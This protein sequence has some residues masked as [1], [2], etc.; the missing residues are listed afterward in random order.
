MKKA[1]IIILIEIAVVVIVFFLF[2]KW[3]PEDR[4]KF[5]ETNNITILSIFLA[6][7]ILCLSMWITLRA[8]F[9]NDSRMADVNMYSYTLQA[10][11]SSG[12]AYKVS[13]IK[14]KEWYKASEACR[15]LVKIRTYSTGF[16]IF[17][18][19]FLAIT[20]IPFLVSRSLFSTVTFAVFLF[21]M[22]LLSYAVIIH[23]F[24]LDYPCLK[25]IVKFPEPELAR[26]PEIQCTIDR[27]KIP[28][29]AGKPKV[30]ENRKRGN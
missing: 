28:P 11:T 8:N 1:I 2:T 17:S 12:L 16:S 14:A 19:L 18:L 10:R 22:A 5:L 13:R 6:I 27:N 15:D 4:I 7:E 20:F 26:Q 30:S 24:S 29:I 23:V 21:S 9:I 25:K 3:L